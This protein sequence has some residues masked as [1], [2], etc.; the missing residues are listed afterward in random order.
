MTS[1]TVFKQSSRSILKSQTWAIFR[2]TI[3]GVF[4]IVLA[5][6][7]QKILHGYFLAAI[8]TVLALYALSEIW[9]VINRRG[10]T[11]KL[12][13]EFTDTSLKFNAN[14]FTGRFP[15]KDLSILS[16]Q[17]SREDIKIITLKQAGGRDVVLSGFEDMEDIYRQLEVRGVC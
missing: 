13:I 17:P 4:A 11:G 2:I 7:G 9:N 16:V 15:Y 3:A 6:G 10:L 14:K 12:T 8:L 5:F 1:V